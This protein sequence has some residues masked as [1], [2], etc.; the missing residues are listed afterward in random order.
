MILCSCRAV[1]ERTIRAAIDAGASSPEEIA[2]MCGAGSRCRGCWPA[3][4]ELLDEAGRPARE[5]R[6]NPAALLVT[7]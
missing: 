7:F 3:L 1:S 6:A 5:E 2:S 4:R